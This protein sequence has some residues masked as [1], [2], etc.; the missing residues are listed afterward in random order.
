MSLPVSFREMSAYFM[1]PALTAVGLLY[2]T[3]VI[4]RS[5]ALGATA[6]P[7]ISLIALATFML[8]AL[9]VTYHVLA[10]VFRPAEANE[11][12]DERDRLIAWRAGNIAGY[13]GGVVIV[14]GL[15]R[16]YFTADGNM[17]FHTIVGALIVGQVAEYVMTVVF[18]RRGGV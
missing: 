9:A 4:N 11:P 16:F 10:A 8:V 6:P 17:L 12:E 15:W 18:Y 2:A 7:S 3:S 1:A 14:T 13:V 5:Q